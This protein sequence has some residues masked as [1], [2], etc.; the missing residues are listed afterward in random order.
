MNLVDLVAEELA[1]IKRQIFGKIND[2]SDIK[3]KFDRPTKT[4]RVLASKIDY[5]SEN[6]LQTGTVNIA[7]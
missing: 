6:E 3:R 2:S 4:N 5:S 7:K 1:V